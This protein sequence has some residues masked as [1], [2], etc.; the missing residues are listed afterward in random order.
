[1]AM[2]ILSGQSNRETLGSSTGL[3]SNLLL[4]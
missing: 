1:M 3:G 2:I 4:L